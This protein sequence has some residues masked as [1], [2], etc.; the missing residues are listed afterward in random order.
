MT[1]ADE[2]P[3]HISCKKSLS[4]AD[5]QAGM[6]KIRDGKASC[7]ELACAVRIEWASCQHVFSAPTEVSL[8]QQ[9]FENKKVYPLHTAME[10]MATWQQNVL[11][12]NVIAVRLCQA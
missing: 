12:V 9:A 7:Q 2:L 5:I 3:R 10:E 4:F 6:A 1:L 8:I 11:S